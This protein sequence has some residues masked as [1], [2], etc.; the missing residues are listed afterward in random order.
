MVVEVSERVEGNQ[1]ANH[2]L[3]HIKPNRFRY[4]SGVS[5]SFY[6]NVVLDAMLLSYCYPRRAHRKNCFNLIASH[7]LLKYIYFFYLKFRFKKFLFFLSQSKNSRLLFSREEIFLDH[8]RVYDFGT[9]YHLNS[10]NS[11]SS[12]FVSSNIY[13]LFGTCDS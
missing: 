2:G 12:V 3:Y 1:G 8:Y 4:Q 5:N 7:C 9:N 11:Y 6:G 13:F 10:K